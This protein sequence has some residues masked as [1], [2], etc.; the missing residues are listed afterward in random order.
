MAVPAH[1]THRF[2]AI[3]VAVGNAEITH[4]AVFVYI[5]EKA[6]VA[7]SGFIDVNAGYSMAVAV[8]ISPESMVRPQGL[9]IAYRNPLLHTGGICLKQR[10]VIIEH[11]V[12]Q[13]YVGREA[14]ILSDGDVFPFFH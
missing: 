3:D 4:N 2:A 8:E 1:G 12:V 7:R 13:A 14:E 10:A 6:A 9:A 5:S 11:P